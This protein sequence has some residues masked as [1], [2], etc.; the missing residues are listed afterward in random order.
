MATWY[1]QDATVGF[2]NIG[3]GGQYV[4]GEPTS[5]I[6][7]NVLILVQGLGTPPFN[8]MAAISEVQ[9]QLGPTASVTT[10]STKAPP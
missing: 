8:E 9:I 6:Q 1:D 4:D 7:R 5:G 2:I 3:D 10:C